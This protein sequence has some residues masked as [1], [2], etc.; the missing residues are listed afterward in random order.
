LATK[1]WIAYDRVHKEFNENNNILL[2]VDNKV[3]ETQVKLV[4]HDKIVNI[5]EKK[6]SNEDIYIILNALQQ[7]DEKIVH[8]LLNDFHKEE[9]EKLIEYLM[10][11]NTKIQFYI[12]Q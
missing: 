8:S 6:K 3:N 4:E 2:E 11:M 9:K 7:G 10:K 1:H 5:E 12:M